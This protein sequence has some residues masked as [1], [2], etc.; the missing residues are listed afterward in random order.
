MKK[1]TF[2]TQRAK[3]SA[4]SYTKTE[5]KLNDNEI[6]LLLGNLVNEFNKAPDKVKEKFIDRVFY[7][8]MQSQKNGNSVSE[9]NNIVNNA[10]HVDNNLNTTTD[11]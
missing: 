2:H 7:Y 10:E 1:Y 3:G 8:V 6:N 5:D 11:N 4:R 9:S